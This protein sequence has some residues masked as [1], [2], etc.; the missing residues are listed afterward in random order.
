MYRSINYSPKDYLFY[1]FPFIT[2]IGFP[3]TKTVHMY[4][5]INIIEMMKFKKHVPLLIS[6]KLSKNGLSWNDGLA[7]MKMHVVESVLSIYIVFLDQPSPPF[8]L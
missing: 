1:I 3:A 7:F 6:K 2:Y 5:K 8:L 4:M